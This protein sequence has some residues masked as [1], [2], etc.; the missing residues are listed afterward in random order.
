MTP[1]SLVLTVSEPLQSAPFLSITPEAGTPI[2]VD[3]TKR[4]RILHTL[5]SLSLRKAPLPARSMPY[6]LPGI[7]VGNRGTE[8]DDGA[9][10]QIDTHG[11][12]VKRLVVEPEDPIQND[13]ENPITVTVTI[14]LDEAIKTGTSPNFSY[15]LSGPGRNA[16]VIN[17]LSEITTLLCLKTHLRSKPQTI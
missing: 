17:T 15:L 4:I 10:I 14:G 8:I 5:A 16:V 9:S 12:A 1:Y 6:S 11:P 7:L 3:L 2:S 13:E